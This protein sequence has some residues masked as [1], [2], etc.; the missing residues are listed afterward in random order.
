M[1][2]LLLAAGAAALAL[3]AGAA[4]AASKHPAHST[5]A[6]SPK[7]PIPYSQLDAYLKASPKQRASM[8]WSGQAATTGTSTNTAATASSAPEAKPDAPSTET[9]AAPVNP[10]ASTPK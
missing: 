8:D 7:E 10:P 6:M 1:K 2:T 3:S 9:P 4:A 5:V